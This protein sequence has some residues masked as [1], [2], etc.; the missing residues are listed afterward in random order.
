MWWSLGAAWRGEWVGCKWGSVN[1]WRVL[2]LFVTTTHSQLAGNNGDR[3][4][5]MIAFI[6]GLNWTHVSVLSA[7][8]VQ[9]TLSACTLPLGR[10]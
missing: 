2:L 5:A 9:H 1:S 7:S 3:N 10:K 6:K 8:D 4:A